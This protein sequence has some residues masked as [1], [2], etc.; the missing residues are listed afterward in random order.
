MSALAVALGA[1]MLVATSVFRSGIEA[2]WTAGANKFAF[3][4]EI[5]NLTFGGVGLMM[6]GAAGFLIYNAFAMSVTQ[7]QRQIGLLRALGMTRAQ[8]LQLVLVEAL[9]TGGLGTALGVLGGP[10]VGNGILS[11]MAHF[12]VETGQGSAAPGSILLAVMMGLGISLLSALVPARRAARLSPLEALWE[13]ESANQRVSEKAGRSRLTFDGR[14][15]AFASRFTM[16][17]ALLLPLWIYLIVAPPGRWTGYHQ[18]WDYILSAALM[19]VWWIGFVLVTPALLGV[20]VRGL[21]A[22]LRR[23]GGGMGRLLGDNLGRAPERLH[24]TA[25]TF[26]VGVLMMVGTGGF[27]SFGN[28]VMVGRIAA[29]AMREQAWYIYP[30]NRVDGLGQ[31]QGFQAD[32]PA[33]EPAI[34]AEIEQLAAGRAVVEPFYMVAV[35]EIS[36]PFP[37][38]PSMVTLNP[39]QL[40]RP[41]RFHMVEGDWEAALT[42]LRE[43]CGVLVSP[44]IAARYGAGVGDPITVTGR[45]GPVTCAVAATGAGGFAPMSI[46]GPG[47][48]DRFVA[49]GKSPDSLQVRPLPDASGADIAAL[50]ADLRALAARY[51][52]DRVFVARPED[53][54]KAITGTSDQLVQ[55]MNGLLLLAVGAG[56]LGSVNTTLVSILERQRELAL[57]RALGATRRQ[58]AGLIVGESAVTG[59]LGALLGLLAGWGTIA[60]YALTYGGVTFGLVDL[61]LWTAVA[62]VTWPALRG[63]LWGLAAAPVLAAVAAFL[64]IRGMDFVNLK[65]E[66]SNVKRESVTLDVLGLRE[67]FVIGA[68]ALL[69]LLMLSLVAAV[70]GHQG[71][72]MDDSARELGAL[73]AQSQAQMLELSLPDDTAMLE[74]SALGGQ[75]MD[76]EQLLALQ[77]LLKD[78]GDVGL[79]A[80]TVA[81]RDNVVLLSLDPREVGTIAPPLKNAEEAVAWSEREDEAWR[82]LATAPVRNAAGDVVGAVRMAFD[83][84]W[85]REALRELRGTLWAAGGG[86]SLLALALAWLL[87]TPL[88]RATQQLA[89]HAAGVARGEYIPFAHPARRS[90]WAW[91]TAR[92][93]LRTRFIVALTLIILLLVVSLEVVTLPIQRRHVEKTLLDGSAA[94]LEWLGGTMS[95]AL[96]Q[97]ELSPGD[98]GADFSL[99]RLLAMSGTLDWGQ[100]QALSEQSRPESLAY[101][102]LVDTDGVV[103]FSDQLA[104]IGEEVGIAAVTETAAR[105]WRNEE[106]WVVSTPLTCGRGGA[107]VGMLQMGMRRAEVEAFLGE[108]RSRWVSLGR[109]IWRWS[110]MGGWR[111]RA[112]SR[113][114]S[115]L[116]RVMS[117]AAFR[118]RE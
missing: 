49:P 28:E 30:F 67:R 99:D 114:S 64:V 117:R 110:R 4:T 25:L 35:P 48:F 105:R 38:F 37:G 33:L 98:L 8:V 56:A 111:S 50:D 72:Y 52:D 54:L 29:Q 1:A 103:R 81:D 62:E 91:I 101:L 109:L 23:L 60:I 34:V 24:L 84:A 89:A 15:R 32:A 79:T 5:S 19:F 51:G 112:F 63:G 74:L 31:L 57:L 7:Q 106:I 11:A 53:E 96:G 73:M 87:A 44:A 12:G 27:V 65:R 47:G 39:E 118:I 66:T 58:I 20:V 76:A 97:E 18:P 36:S 59:L 13:G 17:L 94:T 88:A 107:R 6:L 22:L 45:T 10:L 42:L 82:I 115:D 9:F 102:A 92:T 90:P 16:G 78:V 104:L 116:G 83:L 80:Y 108:R 113:T 75:R 85:A 86:V 2:A 95:E 100:L 14:T 93:S 43:G 61:P 77:S 69:L 26:A 21:R 46:I 40:M 41:G 55:I 71:R 3:I 68:T 70:V